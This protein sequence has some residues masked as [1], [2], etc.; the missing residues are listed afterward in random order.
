[1]AKA[2]ERGLEAVAVRRSL[3][4]DTDWSSAVGGFS[5]IVHLAAAAHE[6][7]ER[8][9]RTNDYQALRSVN[10]LATER[11]AR[12]AHA[13][14]IGR[15]VFI[16]SVGVHGD[17]THG[18]PFTEQ[19]AFAP[20]SLY[21]RSKLEAEERLA[22]VA[23]ATGLAVTVLRPPLVYGPGNPGNML[24]LLRLL[25]GGSPLP[26]ASIE[27]RRSL[28]YVG[29]LADAIM[30]CIESPAAEGRTYLVSDGAP[31]STPELCRALGRA[32]GRPARLFRFPPALLELA[33]PM[34]KLTRS[35]VVDD[36]AIR[37]EL[38]WV[39]PFA[40]EEG[41]RLTAQWYLARR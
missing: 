6:A 32:L 9:E 14:G 28:V 24:R 10:A 37:D 20:R 29:N 8:Y 2:A 30:R 40:F 36:R 18:T 25:D 27:N 33:P 5:A 38:R 13:A 17:G 34:R 35:L 1:M 4:P 26:L 15:F 16:S 31:I 12:E 7:A 3:A 11:L 21:A 39:P 23:R 22:E 41:I 19:S